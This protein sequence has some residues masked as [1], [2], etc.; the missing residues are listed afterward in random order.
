MK[1][2]ITYSESELIEKLILREQEAFTYLYDHY[3]PALTGIIQQII[4]DTETAADVLQ[5]VFLNIWRKIGSYD[6]GKGRLF[7]WMLNIARNAAIDMVRSKPWRENQ[8]NQPIPE[9]VYNL[10]K[11]V[12]Q[13]DPDDTGLRKMVSQLKDDYKTLVELSYFQGYTHEELSK[14]LNIPLGTVKT[15]IRSALI[16]LRKILD[17]R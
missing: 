9:D 5:Q 16:Q 15:R 17:K 3:A 13:P 6:A 11:P 12:F 7:T 1:Q 10:G 4:P 2:E 8:Q 14:M